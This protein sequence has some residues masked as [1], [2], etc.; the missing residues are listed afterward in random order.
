MGKVW[1]QVWT[2]GA[3]GGPAP[4]V[5]FLFYMNVSETRPRSHL[6]SKPVMIPAPWVILHVEWSIFVV[7]PWVNASRFLG[8]NREGQLKTTTFSSFL[9]FR[10]FLVFL[11]S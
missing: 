6:S 2:G 9:L 8:V 1:V 11:F 10:I 3:Q 7:L 5:L 4:L